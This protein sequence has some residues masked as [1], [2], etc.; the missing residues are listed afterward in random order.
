MLKIKK[1]LSLQPLIDSFKD[2]FSD[3]DKND[4]RRQRSVDY[5]KLDT[6]LAGLACMFYK[7]SDMV[8]FQERMKKRC[9]KSNLETQFGVSQVPKDNQ[10]REILGN[11]S[12]KFNPL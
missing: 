9:Y 4:T 1:N 10:M 3:I 2:K 11:L 12:S 6:S 5:R 7:S 8:S